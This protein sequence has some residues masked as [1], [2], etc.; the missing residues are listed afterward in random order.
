M[1]PSRGGSSVGVSAVV[2]EAAA[3]AAA[4][5]LCAAGH[6]DVVIEGLARGTEFSVIVLG[7]PPGGAGGPVA[8]LPSQ[9]E[10]IDENHARSAAARSAAARSAAGGATA[11]AEPEPST[12]GRIF[13]FRDKYLPSTRVVIHT[14]P[15]ALSPDTTRRIR[16]AAERAFRE[17][18]LRDFARL[19]GAQ[20]LLVFQP[21]VVCVPAAEGLLTHPCGSAQVSSSPLR[22]RFAPVYSEEARPRA[23]APP[24]PQRRPRTASLCSRT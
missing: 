3:A 22:P 17:L 6:G 19:D 9:V 23:R 5:A 2:G 20:A 12:S 8:L 16:R 7:G 15:S 10:I 24:G 1:K 4:A 13:G 18:G 21:R 14:P 11:A